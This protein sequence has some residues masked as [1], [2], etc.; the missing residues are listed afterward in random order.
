MLL[1]V[2]SFGKMVNELTAYRYQGGKL[3]ASVHYF[4]KYS[5]KLVE[6]RKKDD[7]SKYKAQEKLQQ[8]AFYTKQSYDNF[9]KGT[10]DYFK[11][12]SQQD[13]EQLQK[14]MVAFGSDDQS[15][16]ETCK[17]QYVG[18][19]TVNVLSSSIRATPKIR[20]VLVQN[21]SEYA[22]ASAFLDSLDIL[23]PQTV[24]RVSEV[25]NEEV[26]NKM[27]DKLCHYQKHQY[28]PWHKN[29]PAKCT[30]DWMIMASEFFEQAK[31]SEIV[32]PEPVEEQ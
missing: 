6:A 27:I 7:K 30:T 16:L 15:G 2:S 8:L 26:Y 3:V 32:E 14:L 28:C 5:G 20:F 18:R 12:S 11:F 4:V 24:M 29:N 19:A 23:Y 10:V 31:D 13:L 25:V 1:N 21:D 22:D 9:L 17:T